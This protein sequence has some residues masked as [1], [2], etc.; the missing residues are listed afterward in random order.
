M[1][2]VATVFW[3]IGVSWLLNNILITFRVP[4][5]HSI[6]STM[7][8]SI[9]GKREIIVHI[10]FWAVYISFM[11]NHISSYQKSPEVDWGKVLTEAFISLIYMLSISYLN[12]FY[13]IPNFLIRKE[14]GKFLLGFAIAFAAI[15][16]FR[17]EIE[18]LIIAE[19]PGGAQSPPRTRFI[20]QDIIS[21]LFIVMFVGLLRFASDWLHLDSKRREIETEKLAAELIFLKAQVNPHFFFNT[22]NNLYYLATIKS[23]VTPQVISKLSE[24]MRY[25]IYDSNHDRVE[26]IR[27]I[28][29]IHNYISLERL[30]IK[31]GIVL[32]FEVEGRT[33]I[34][35]TP[36]ILITFLENA[37]KHG[38]NSTNSQCWIKAKLKVEGTQLNFTIANS[39]ANS[40]PE[41][42]EK[43]GIG[44]KNVKRRLDLSY[45]EKYRLNIEDNPSTFFVSLT[46]QLK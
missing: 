19:S 3:S 10:A 30:R 36:L 39:K 20:I 32:A 14:I 7:A 46:I 45:P 4:G 15:S 18:K 2:S 22:L 24:V 44:L 29:Y 41:A 40:K 13:F 1:T 43:P 11:I 12:Y 21:N 31:E 9:M 23:D 35:I 38:V 37:F 27:E 34:L 33:D 42:M 6:N 5:Y 16:L 28:E 26:L 17:F 8:F 25:M